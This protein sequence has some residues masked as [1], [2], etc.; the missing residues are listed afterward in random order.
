LNGK[1]KKAIYNSLS[2]GFFEGI[3]DNYFKK[4]LKAPLICSSSVAIPKNIFLKVGNFDEN[5]SRGED[6]DM[7]FRIALSFPV[8]FNN[9]VCISYYKVNN[10]NIYGDFSVRNYK[11]SFPYK[12]E[13]SI[14]EFSKINTN[15]YFK[16]YIDKQFI[17]ISRKFIL[18]GNNKKVKELLNKL[19]YNKY[20]SK[21]WI[22]FYLLSMLP[23]NFIKIIK[24]LKDKINLRILSDL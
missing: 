24:N 8:A 9:N 20:H 16:K 11:K 23:Y 10:E 3:I 21:D 19:C 13:K 18:N 2:V 7:W 12:L 4:C 5:L 6:L 14:K 17:K 22:K 15:K 1:V